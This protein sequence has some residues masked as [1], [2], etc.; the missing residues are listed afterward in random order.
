MSE[1]LALLLEES[2]FYFA[3]AESVVS[4][5]KGKADAK[6]LKEACLIAAQNERLTPQN[7]INL[8]D[9]VRV[10]KHW[11][12]D[13]IGQE[14]EVIRLERRVFKDDKG[15]RVQESAELNKNGTYYGPVLIENLEKIES[16]A[17]CE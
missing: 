16:E 3:H 12:K 5:V 9:K 8:L 11:A 13:M 7:Q 4:S 1:T 10:V 14:F 2:A 15:I 6:K 17:D